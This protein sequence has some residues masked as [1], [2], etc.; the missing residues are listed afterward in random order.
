[1]K[2]SLL[3]QRTT[4]Q[5]F[6][7]LG[8]MLLF[9]TLSWGQTTVFNDAFAGNQSASNVASYVTAGASSGTVPGA[10]NYTA[11]ESGSFFSR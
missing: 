10:I 5:F 7:I 3:N 11:Y 1:M 9:S 2:K 8:L 6:S 4:L